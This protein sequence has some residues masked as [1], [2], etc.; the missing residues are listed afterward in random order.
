M[1]LTFISR[2]IPTK[3]VKIIGILFV[4]FVLLVGIV[5]NNYYKEMLQDRKGKAEKLVET[6]IHLVGYY[7]RKAHDGS[8]PEAQAKRFAIEALQHISPRNES[9]YWVVNT[10]AVIEMHP[11]RPD[12][13]GKDMKNYVGPDGR[14]LFAEIAKTAK[15][16]KKWY[17]EYMWTKSDQNDGTLYP[18]I[19]YMELFE[20]WDIVIGSGV[21]IDDIHNAFWSAVYVAG[22]I[23]VAF[24]MFLMALGMTV[25]ENI[26]KT[27]G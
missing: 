20:P 2:F 27:K 15:T 26:N 16:Q 6:A 12:I 13:V 25:T 4:M 18:K 10:D 24:L 19:S 22:G 14:R 17:L 5:L 9:Y 3:V 23:S 11:T 8:M 1:N 21:Y 7:Y